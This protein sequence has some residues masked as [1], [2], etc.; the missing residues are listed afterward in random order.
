MSSESALQ[1]SFDD[2]SSEQALEKIRTTDPNTLSPIE[3]LNVLYEL[4]TLVK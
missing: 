1:I 2:N 3:A 4:K